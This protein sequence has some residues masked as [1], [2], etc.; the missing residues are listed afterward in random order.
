VVAKEYLIKKRGKKPAIAVDTSI[1]L[2]A[3]KARE[4]ANV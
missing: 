2:I 3:Q 4:L 1:E